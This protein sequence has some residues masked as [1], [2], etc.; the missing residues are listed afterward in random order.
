M[1]FCF[2]EKHA[3][4]H[5][6]VLCSLKRLGHKSSRRCSHPPP[7]SHFWPSWMSRSLWPSR[8]SIRS[9]N[10]GE[11]KEVRWVTCRWPPVLFGHL[12]DRFAVGKGIG[13]H[14]DVIQSP[15]WATSH[16]ENTAN[17]F[18]KVASSD[19]FE[20]NV[21]R[22]AGSMILC[23]WDDDDK[24]GTDLMCFFR[25]HLGKSHEYVDRRLFL[26]SFWQKHR[27]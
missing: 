10:C 6:F 7:T 20:P 21:Q 22:K 14:C 5:W 16:V 13:G 1:G 8:M 27:F 11:R 2:L 19:H 15:R 3:F 26:L 23:K 25:S 24:F 9:R 12:V 18:E 17:R 4:W